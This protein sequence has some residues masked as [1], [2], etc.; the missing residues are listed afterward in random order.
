MTVVAHL[1]TSRHFDEG[2]YAVS[3]RP[4]HEVLRYEAG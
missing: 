3:D 1:V 4:T 2:R